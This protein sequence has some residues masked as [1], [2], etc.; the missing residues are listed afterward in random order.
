LKKAVTFLWVCAISTIVFAQYRYDDAIHL[1]NGA[2]VHGRIIEVIPHRQLTIET[3]DR[4]TLV[5]QLSEVAK[6]YKRT[7]PSNEQ[8]KAAPN[9]QPEITKKAQKTPAKPVL[10]E[11]ED[12]T[13]SSFRDVIDPDVTIVSK[14]AEKLSD[15]PGIVSVITR[16]ELERFGGSTLMDILERVPG[17]IG[18]IS[19]DRRY[20]MASRG[21]QIES[22][23]Y[24]YNGTTSRVLLLINGRPVRETFDDAGIAYEIYETFP[25]SIIE[26]I[27]VA[28]GPN[29]VIYGSNAFSALINVVTDKAEKSGMSVS[30]LAGRS[31][32]GK[33]S[34]KVSFKTGDLRILASGSYFRKPDWHTDY[35]TPA[36]RGGF[37]RDSIMIAG[38]GPGAYLGINYKNFNVMTSYNRYNQRRSSDLYHWIF[39]ST[40]YEKIFCSAGYDTQVNKR[41]HTNVSADLTDAHSIHYS[42]EFLA[43]W[44]NIIDLTEKSRLIAGG[45]YNHYHGNNYGYYYGGSPYLSRFGYGLYA[46]MEYLLLESLKCIGGV[47]MYKI[48]N[49]DVDFVPSAGVVWN[50]WPHFNVKALYGQAFALSGSQISGDPYTGSSVKPEKVESFDVSVGYEGARF[51]TA[52]NLF[53]SKMSNSNYYNDFRYYPYIVAQGKKDLANSSKG[54]EF[55]GKWYII[56]SLFITGSLLYHDTRESNGL[57]MPISKWGAKGGISFSGNRGITVSFFNIYQGDLDSV[58]KNISPNPTPGFYDLLYGYCKI[59]INKLFNLRFRPG[60]ALIVQADNLSD[61]KVWT[62]SSVPSPGNNMPIPYKQGRVIYAGLRVSL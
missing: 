54:I 49:L 59:D 58:Y 37:L 16:D 34:G 24:G 36:F 30:G 33:T 31:G 2:I 20:I 60:I 13:L 46:Q 47:R 14:Y 48:Q 51:L 26:R 41:W 45:L 1:K 21:N 17:L 56:K 3:A 44:T 9:S 38:K 11:K 62:F 27:E 50:L 57:A 43:E 6:Y 5:Y 53:R 7:Y 61:K 55:E 4:I 52:V 10:A 15:A 19:G 8:I 22:S 32:S 40:Y 29:S 42:R 18:T 23:F 39:D 12:G 28:R 25:V 35:F